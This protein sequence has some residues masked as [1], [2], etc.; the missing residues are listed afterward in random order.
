MARISL[1]EAQAWAE[2]SK[3]DLTDMGGLDPNLLTQVEAQVLGALGR[4]YD[5]AVIQALWVNDATTPQLVR[6]LIAMRYMSLLYDRQYSEDEGRN[7]WARRL[8]N[9]ANDLT[10]AIATGAVDIPEIAGVVGVAREPRFYPTDDSSSQ[11]G[12][13]ALDPGAGPPLFTVGMVL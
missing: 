1:T 10:E 11:T 9:M 7:P 4:V 13:T 12:P 8:E 3:M 5:P 6:T 2:S